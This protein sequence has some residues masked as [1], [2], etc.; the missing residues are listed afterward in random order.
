MEL[1]LFQ[2]ELVWECVCFG[3]IR[4]RRDIPQPTLDWSPDL[5]SFDQMKRPFE[6]VSPYKS[7]KLRVIIYSLQSYLSSCQCAPITAVWSLSASVWERWN[8]LDE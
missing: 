4:K 2:L 6:E 5:A 8:I 7:N 1:A 3:T